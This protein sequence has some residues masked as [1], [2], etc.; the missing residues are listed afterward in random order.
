[1]KPN[2]QLTLWAVLIT[3]TLAAQQG[4]FSTYL[5]D[6]ANYLPVP[7]ASVDP[8]I[9]QSGSGYTVN[10]TESGIE[11]LLSD[12]LLLE[13]ERTI[14][15]DQKR[16]IREIGTAYHLTLFRKEKNRSFNFSLTAGTAGNLQLSKDDE[17]LALDFAYSKDTT[18]Y[19]EY[20]ISETEKVVRAVDVK[21]TAGTRALLKVTQ[22][23]KG[24]GL[25][26]PAI[27][28]GVELNRASAQAE[29]SLLGIVTDETVRVL[30]QEFSFGSLIGKFDVAAFVALSAAMQKVMDQVDLDTVVNPVEMVT[31]VRAQRVPF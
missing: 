21:I 29:L 24:I 9:T 16:T 4:S 5:Q 15:T 19:F 22:R 31:G 12:Q 30:N 23:K 1:M 20:R 6:S 10:Y 8:D 27:T 7:R 26:F 11:T 3:T 17:A 13:E 2:F 14:F 18:Y 28:A 25:S